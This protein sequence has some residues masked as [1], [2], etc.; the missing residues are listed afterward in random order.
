MKKKILKSLM[1]VFVTVTFIGVGS[2]FAGRTDFNA[3]L[4]SFGMHATVVDYKYKT[5]DVDGS[6][7][8]LNSAT[9]KSDKVTVWTDI[10]FRNGGAEIQFSPFVEISTKRGSGYSHWLG[11]YVQYSG[12]KGDQI[13]LRMKSGSWGSDNVSGSWDYK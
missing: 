11:S 4:P 9:S 2:V 1:L 13:K 8:M 10:K 6:I 7:L 12:S 5:T 3:S